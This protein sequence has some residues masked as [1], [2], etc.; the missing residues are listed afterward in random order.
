[1]NPEIIFDNEF[2][3][4]QKLKEMVNSFCDNHPALIE[5]VEKEYTRYANAIQQKKE[6]T[7][8][9]CTNCI[10]RIINECGND[11]DTIIL[12]LGKTLRF[13]ENYAK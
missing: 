12:E 9:P 6:K 2:V 1:M 13:M 4:N 10:A 3:I 5:A 8:V 11:S 7:C